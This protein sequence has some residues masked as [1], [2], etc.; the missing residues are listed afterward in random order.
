MPLIRARV[1]VRLKEGIADP[2]GDT[3]GESL[4]DLGYR[5]AGVRSGKVY[6]IIL[7]AESLERASRILE[8]ICDRLLAN[9]VKDRCSYEVSGA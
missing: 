5:V 6:E 9:P 2:E 1:F 4:R 8:E 3:V 7:E